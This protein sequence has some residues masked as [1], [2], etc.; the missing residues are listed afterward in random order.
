MIFLLMLCL[1]F[2]VGLPVFMYYSAKFK[3]PYKLIMVF[4]KKGAGKTTY[5]A[6]ES[7]KFIKKGRPVF[8]TVY[9]P[10]T[11]LFN[12]D[13]IG[14]KTFPKDAVIFIDEVGMIWDNRQFKNF[15][16]EVRDY[17]KLQRHYGHTVYLFS[18][19]FDIDIKLRNLTDEM[20]LCKCW[21][22]FISVARRIKRDIVLTQPTGD[23][24]ARIADSLEF[25]PLWLSLF[26]GGTIKFTFI[27]RW[28]KLFNSFET[29]ELPMVDAV[30]QEIPCTALSLYRPMGV[31]MIEKG[32]MVSYWLS[33]Q[34]NRHRR[35]GKED[36]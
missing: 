35:N 15:K 14:K 31:N 5:I 12:V 29:P 36:V 21:F 24:E 7:T 26:G 33:K 10:G 23:S 32:R 8:S 30:Y 20:Y 13:Q 22:S 6:K 2:S 16:P 4:G 18:Q 19:S 9:V 25:Y 27:P 34:F 1:M 3:N 28:C 11:H 17:F